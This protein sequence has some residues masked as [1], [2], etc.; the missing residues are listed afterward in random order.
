MHEWSR[1]MHIHLLVSCVRH[2]SYVCHMSYVSVCAGELCGL[3]HLRELDLDG[4]RFTGPF[5]DW[6]LSCFPLLQEL[7]LSYNRVRKRTTVAHMNA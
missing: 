2:M 6:V 1:I 3:H 4:S 7:D 5:P